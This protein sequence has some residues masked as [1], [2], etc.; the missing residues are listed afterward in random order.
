[1]RD[2]EVNGP[3]PLMALTFDDGPHPT[4]T[5]Q[6]LKVLK[7]YGARATFFVVGRWVDQCPGVIRELVEA[8]QEIGNH[9]YSHANLAGRSAAE[10]VSELTRA[11]DA[12]CRVI[13]RVPVLVR[14]PYGAVDATVREVCSRLGRRI[15]LWTLDSGDW[16][17]PGVSAIVNRV[18]RQSGPGTVALLHDGGG[19]RRQTVQALPAI[20]E[21]LQTRGFRLVTVGRLIQAGLDVPGPANFRGRSNP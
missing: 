11:D 1:L 5:A 17:D 3:G 8:G 4:C 16:Q 12:I 10:V 7:R 19:D 14:P 9:S 21:R 20:I 15:I 2:T 6:V 18:V 13:H